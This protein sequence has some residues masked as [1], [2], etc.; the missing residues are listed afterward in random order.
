[1]FFFFY[2]GAALIST[3]IWGTIAGKRAID[4]AEDRHDL[5]KRERAARGQDTHGV[6]LAQ[7]RM[8]KTLIWVGLGVLFIGGAING[9]IGFAGLITLLIGWGI[10]SQRKH[11]ADLHHAA[12]HAE[13]VRQAE[14]DYADGWQ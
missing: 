10:L 6:P 14:E 7:R 13:A 8:P 1:M 4:R 12:A 2:R 5:R 9:A 11:T 3:L